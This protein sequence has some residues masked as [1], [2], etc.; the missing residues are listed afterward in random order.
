M[1]VAIISDLHGN[2]EAL[3]ALPEE[4]DALW[5]LG[6]LV[7]YGPNPGEV[8]E[9]VRKR[10]AVI[11]RGNHDHAIA[12]GEDCRCSARFRQMAEA[13]RALTERLLSAEQKSFLRELPEC[14][15]RQIEK[16]IFFL[17]HATP[18]NPLFEYRN[19]DS[20]KWEVEEAALGADVILGGHTHIPFVRAFG[21]RIV[22]NPGSLGQS[23]AGGPSARY[24]VW[25]DG[26]IELRSYGYPVEVT[27]AKIHELSLPDEVRRDLITVLST[28]TVPPKR[29]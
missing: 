7:N 26:R 12:F 24:A 6:D 27:V 9:W 28:G 14:A 18:S 22:A 13:T 1:R 23:K 17:C 25:E 3:S 8:I 21:N 15:S 29:Q 20:V 10:A 19:P 4:Y 2:L 5:V 11:V 16:T